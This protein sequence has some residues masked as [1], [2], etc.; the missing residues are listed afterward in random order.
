M[1]RMVL[2]AAVQRNKMKVHKIIFELTLRE[3]DVELVV[4]KVQDRAAQSWDNVEKKQEDIIRK[5]IEIKETFAQ[6]K[7]NAM[8]QKENAQP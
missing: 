4:E 3:D 1:K 5:L 7:L 6:L 2:W 8:Q